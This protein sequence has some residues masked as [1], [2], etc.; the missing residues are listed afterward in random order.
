MTVHGWD[1]S[2]YDFSRG[3]MDLDAAFRD[4][5]RLFTCKATEGVSYRDPNFGAA[6]NRAHAAGIPVLGAYH[7]VHT[8]PPIG[9]QV[10]YLVAYLDS[11]APWWRTHP[12]FIVQVDLERWPG[13]SV[14]AS[15]GCAFADA[16]RRATGE[17]VIIYASRGQYGNT[18]PAGCDLWNAA[19]PSSNAAHYSTL[20]PGDGGSGWNVYSGRT[21]VIWQY[22]ST[23]T[24]GTQPGC[25]ANAYRGTLDQLLALTRSGGPPS[26][27]GVLMALND[28]QQAQLFERVEA[29]IYG[30]DSA[31]DNGSG[32]KVTEPNGGMYVLNGAATRL[33]AI[34][35][36][37]AAQTQTIT[38]LAT[39]L[40]QA[41]TPDVAP[42]VQQIQALITQV[43][44]LA[45]T[46]AAQTA[47]IATLQARL[48]AAVQAEAD[49]L[50]AA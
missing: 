24:I 20:Y 49:T 21:P 50:G 19:Y 6:I 37:L 28:L 8:T 42:L 15:V 38:N 4:G 33:A 35:T 34:Q 36:T 45:S 27:S 43:A 41:G 16:A 18:V 47:Q 1:A 48:A 31:T 3:A 40:Q 7:V 39:L 9:A 13:D 26:T 5:I 32:G 2:H 10:A 12:N 17:Y 23:A 25:D 14:P 46:E 30:R 29:L 44:Q 11:A 22:A